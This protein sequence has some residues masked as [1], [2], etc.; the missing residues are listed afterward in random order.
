MRHGRAY[1]QCILRPCNVC[2]QCC[3]FWWR[4]FHML[5]PRRQKGLRVQI[6][7]FCCFF[8]SNVVAVK[9]LKSNNKQTT[10]ETA[11]RRSRRRKKEALYTLTPRGRWDENSSWRCSR[12]W[13]ATSPRPRPHLLQ[14]GSQ[15][16]RSGAGGRGWRERQGPEIS[17]SSSG[18]PRLSLTSSQVHSLQHFHP[19]GRRGVLGGWC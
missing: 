19:I 4:S 7:H 6:S 10:K 17:S 12:T 5:V 1:K 3:A 18:L 11:R 8:S 13:T 16:P 14:R 15:S 2:S 9:V